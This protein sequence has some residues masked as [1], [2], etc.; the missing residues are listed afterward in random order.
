MVTDSRTGEAPPAQ[1][2]P[3]PF[4]VAAQSS[5]TRFL[6]VGEELKK[7]RT[8]PPAAADPFRIVKPST[9]ASGDSCPWK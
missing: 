7:H 6:S 1:T 5:I 2:S 4:P 8:P 3:P 9:T